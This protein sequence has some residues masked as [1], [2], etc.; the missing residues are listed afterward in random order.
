MP[1]PDRVHAAPAQYQ[2]TPAAF[3]GEATRWRVPALIGF[4][5]RGSKACRFKLSA[6]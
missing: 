2:P 6:R 5:T 1:L 3:D 4:H